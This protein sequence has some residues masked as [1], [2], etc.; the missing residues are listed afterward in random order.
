VRYTHNG[1]VISVSFFYLYRNSRHFYRTKCN[2]ISK[3]GRLQ[4]A[5]ELGSWAHQCPGLLSPEQ[6]QTVGPVGPATEKALGQYVHCCKDSAIDGGCAVKM[7]L[8]SDMR[9]LLIINYIEK[10]HTVYLKLYKPKL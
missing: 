4:R 7:P 10:L 1:A 9:L 8:S 6:F 5:S 2:T 3:K